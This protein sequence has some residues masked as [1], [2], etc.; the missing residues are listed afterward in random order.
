M[1]NIRINKIVISKKE[2]EN[3]SVDIETN[4][5]IPEA[6]YLLDLAKFHLLQ[7]HSEEGCHLKKLEEYNEN[8]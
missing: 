6:I 7:I 4:L 5:G 2:G 3:E 1:S 8:N